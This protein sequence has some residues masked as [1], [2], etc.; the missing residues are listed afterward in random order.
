[1]FNKLKSIR[2]IT[3]LF[4]IGTV[5]IFL[6][7]GN[8]T[9]DIPFQYQHE[10][11]QDAITTTNTTDSFK[12]AT[13]D[14]YYKMIREDPDYERRLRELEIFTKNYIK[15]INPENRSIV[16]IPVVV[17]VVYN[18]PVQNISNAVVQSQI[19]ILNLDYRRLDADTVNTPASFK[20]L[21]GDPQIEFV[22]AKRDPVGNP[23]IGITR[24]QTSVVTFY[25]GDSIFYT[26]LGGHDIWD[27]DKY[28][29]IWIC[30]LSFPGGFSQFPGGDPA[31]DGNVMKYTIFGTIGAVVPGYTKG[32]IATHEIGHW[33]NLRHIWG[34]AYCGND[35]VDDTPTQQ[36][37]NSGCPGFPHVT[38][39]N[40][41]NGDMF[42]NYMDYTSDDCKNIYTI[43]QSARMNACLNG[44]RSGLLTSNG[45][46]PVSGVPIAHFRSDKMTIIIG[47][48]INFFDESGGIPTGWQWTFDGGVPS[49]SNQQN[50]SVTYT[51][52]GLYSVKLKVTNSYGTD[53]VNYVNYIKVLGV[54]MSS[55]SIVYPPSNTF[56]NTYTTDT[57]RSVFTWNKTSS[58][59]TIR[60][61]WK[62]RK[63]GGTVDLSYN[64]DNNGSDTLITLRNS[65]LDSLAIGFGGNSDTV[66]CLWR[67]YSYNGSD[68]LSSQNANFVFI[69]RRTVGIKVIS[70]SVPGEYKLFQNY[71]NPFNPITKINF[72]IAK[73]GFVSLV[74]YDALGRQVETL[75]NQK[76]NAG[77]YIIEFNAG[78]TTGQG[79]KLSSGVYF[80]RLST[81]EFTD[82]KKFV[83]LK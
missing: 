50:P 80:Y 45:G 49:V 1:M 59:P 26:A 35:F 41:P 25:L 17:H 3:T 61:K 64:S 53:S 81:D 46:V 34:D 7:N 27:R 76:M 39:N 78:L 75:V 52:A 56:I 77:S 10:P 69:A 37:A 20:P 14:V 16:K 63:D 22:L 21:G 58:H 62:I 71:P 8:S 54:N 19:D 74:I 36:A 68:S 6:L 11:K 82:I 83:L 48:S 66:S 18:L 33:F 40:G 12:C 13:M 28:L 65:F 32:R 29:N 31:T 67:V 30:N 44:A 79:S 9:S 38:C 55:F 43:G 51:N 2:S 73:T 70:S 5:F 23:S 72:D 24:T 15:N 47:Q 57:A 42:T 4:F 60:Y